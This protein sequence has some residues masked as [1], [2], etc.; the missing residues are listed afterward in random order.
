MEAG[1]ESSFVLKRI[2]CSKIVDV[3]WGF[4]VNKNMCFMKIQEN[5]DVFTSV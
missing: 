5:V 1:L 2:P 4:K 3:F